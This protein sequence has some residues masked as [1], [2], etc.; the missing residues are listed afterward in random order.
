MRYAKVEREQASATQERA[1]A[2]AS[3][4]LQATQADLAATNEVEKE[5]LVAA[6]SPP[7][8][9]S[10]SPRAASAARSWTSQRQSLGP[11]LN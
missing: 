11:P 6:R 8:Q 9:M 2:A 3:G 7:K 10:A 4:P 5:L 1:M